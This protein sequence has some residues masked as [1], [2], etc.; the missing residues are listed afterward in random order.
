MFRLG[1]AVWSNAKESDDEEL[2]E[3]DAGRAGD[4]AV[5]GGC[6]GG[7]NATSEFGALNLVAATAIAAECAWCPA[8][9]GGTAN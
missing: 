4:G 5:R 9:F 6:A 1:I 8:P 2:E 7:A 3:D